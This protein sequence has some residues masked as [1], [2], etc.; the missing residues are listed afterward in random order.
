MEVKINSR[1]EINQIV[2]LM[3]LDKENKTII[4]Q[5]VRVTGIKF[6]LHL[7]EA[8]PTTAQSRENMLVVYSVELNDGDHINAPE[9]D[10]YQD[11]AE[12]GGAIQARYAVFYHLKTNS[13]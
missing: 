12:A 8:D 2:I 7:S 10:L 6:S 1:F 11:L 13:K 3:E 4:L 5:E 9:C